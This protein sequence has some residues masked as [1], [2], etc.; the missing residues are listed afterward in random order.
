MAKISKFINSLGTNVVVNDPI[1]IKIII[2]SSTAFLIMKMLCTVDYRPRFRFC[3][4][5]NVS[6]K[7]CT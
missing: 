2:R 1:N 6:Q 3:E 5:L 4:H 7:S